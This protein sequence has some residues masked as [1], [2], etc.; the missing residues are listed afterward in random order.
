MTRLGKV[1]Y[2]IIAFIINDDFTNL[3]KNYREHFLI[4][5]GQIYGS[6]AEKPNK[7]NV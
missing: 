1:D 3:K 6:W 4:Y 5:S 7:L 2:K